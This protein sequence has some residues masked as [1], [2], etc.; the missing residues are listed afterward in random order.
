MWMPDVLVKICLMLH[1]D[2]LYSTKHGLGCIGD[3]QKSGQDMSH[4]LGYMMHRWYAW[5]HDEDMSH[6]AC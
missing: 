2:I 6:V 5:R 4:I 1:T 3:M